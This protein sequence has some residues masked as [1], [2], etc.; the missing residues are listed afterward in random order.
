MM[1]LALGIT[2]SELS[3]TGPVWYAL[4]LALV[5]VCVAVAW[6]WNRRATCGG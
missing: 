3:A 5:L 2:Y 4:G 1:W 6:R